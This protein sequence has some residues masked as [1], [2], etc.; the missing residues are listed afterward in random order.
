MNRLFFAF[1]FVCLSLSGMEQ[2]SSERAAVE[3]ELSVD[4]KLTEYLRKDLGIDHADQKY[5]DIETKLF[6]YRFLAVVKERA[7]LLQGPQIKKAFCKLYSNP[8]TRLNAEGILHVNGLLVAEAKRSILAERRSITYITQG[9]YD[10]PWIVRPY[11]DQQWKA[12]RARMGI[13]P[14]L[15]VDAARN[16]LAEKATAVSSDSSDEDISMAAPTRPPYY[17]N[18]KKDKDGDDG[19]GRDPWP[20]AVF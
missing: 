15:S 16:R 11:F 19:Y 4:R 3:F 10:Q 7:V 14:K 20:L 9:T 8:K 17:Y 6:V 2:V 18:Y 13:Y 12:L 1:S 5:G